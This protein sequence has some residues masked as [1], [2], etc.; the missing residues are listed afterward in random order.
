M[1][2][3]MLVGLVVW[4]FIGIPV[5]GFVVYVLTAPF[6]ALSRKRNER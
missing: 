2:V 1:T 6:R 3:E 5:L 4:L